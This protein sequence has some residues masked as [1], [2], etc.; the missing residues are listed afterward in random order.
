MPV[1]YEHADNLIY[2]MQRNK[3]AENRNL[4]AFIQDGQQQGKQG[5]SETGNQHGREQEVA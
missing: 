1:P 3:T 2:A 4:G 5:M